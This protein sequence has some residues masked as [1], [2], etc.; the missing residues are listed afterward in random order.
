[1]NQTLLLCLGNHTSTLRWGTEGS[2][3][4][5]KAMAP[6]LWMEEPGRLQSMG[7]R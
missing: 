1:M 7:S 4:V 2:F 6:I 3:G 5:S